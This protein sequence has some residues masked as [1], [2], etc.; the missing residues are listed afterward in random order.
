[1]A[2]TFDG[3]ALTDP[4]QVSGTWYP[5]YISRRDSS[6]LY[7][8]YEA[9]K[10]KHFEEPIHKASREDMSRLRTGLG[11]GPPAPKKKPAA[12][13]PVA[14]AKPPAK[15]KTVAK[16]PAAVEKKPAAAKRKSPTKKKKS[17]ARKKK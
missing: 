1:L 6:T 5:G 8:R 12:R 17:P 15:K 13:K 2:Y 3:T 7:F 11:S 16:K 9:S 14:K 10:F 4:T